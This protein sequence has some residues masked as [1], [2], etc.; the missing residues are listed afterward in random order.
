MSVV[1]LIAVCA[2]LALAVAAYFALK[3]KSLKLTAAE[4]GASEAVV[5]RLREIS[6]AIAEGAMAFL[7]QEYSLWRCFR[8][9]LR[10]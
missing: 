4:V 2:L 7:A 5:A 3:V 1:G 9:R 6:D 8:L 10:L